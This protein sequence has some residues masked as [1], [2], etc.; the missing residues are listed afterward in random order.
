MDEAGRTDSPIQEEDAYKAQQ[1]S[2]SVP[3]TASIP[4]PTLPRRPVVPMRRPFPRKISL[5]EPQPVPESLVL[6]FPSQDRAEEFMRVCL[7]GDPVAEEPAPLPDTILQSGGPMMLPVPVPKQVRTSFSSALSAV[8]SHDDEASEPPAEAAGLDDSA[9]SSSGQT[10]G[11]EVQDE[12]SSTHTSEGL[13]ETPG[14]Q[15]NMDEAFREIQKREEKHPSIRA[16]AEQLQ[17]SQIRQQQ[18]WLDLLERRVLQQTAISEVGAESFT[19][20]R[21]VR[22]SANVRQV[23]SAGTHLSWLLVLEQI[24]C[25]WAA[26]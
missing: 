16:P 13:L 3:Q 23:S 8:S 25:S 24:L 17:Y 7:H 26:A 2:V 1:I 11:Q 18:H 5:E 6:G 10:D 12:G 14:V 4:T 21:S 20:C 19:F 9:E 15:S 22:S